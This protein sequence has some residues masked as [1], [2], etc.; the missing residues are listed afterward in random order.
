M[1]T[2]LFWVDLPKAIYVISVDLFLKC[3]QIIIFMR[4]SFIY[5]IMPLLAF[6]SK[7]TPLSINR[8]VNN[9]TIYTAIYHL[10]AI[11]RFKYL[12]CTILLA[13]LSGFMMF[14]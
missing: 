3:Q 5:P 6:N 8:F 12:H 4:N 9:K 11:Y 14:L 1:K 13:V 10:D 7:P 2:L